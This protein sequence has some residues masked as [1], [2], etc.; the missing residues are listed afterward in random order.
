[1][2]QAMSKLL[3]LLLCI[4][5]LIEISVCASVYSLLRSDC[6]V[7]V[8]GFVYVSGSF[9]V[10]TSYSFSSSLRVGFLYS[11]GFDDG[12]FTEV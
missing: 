6:G 8:F 2:Y 5:C 11:D 3:L 12:G 9:C 10:F 7:S 4:D 1:M